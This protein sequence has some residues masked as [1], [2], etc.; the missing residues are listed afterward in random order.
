MVLGR[1]DPLPLFPFPFL[2]MISPLRTSTVGGIFPRDCCSVAVTH[3][4][5]RSAPGST[6]PSPCCRRVSQPGWLAKVVVVLANHPGRTESEASFA[7]EPLALYPSPDRCSTT[8][9]C[10]PVRGLEGP[11]AGTTIYGFSR[12]FTVQLTS[13]IH[14]HARPQAR[15]SKGAPFYLVY[16]GLL[17]YH[18]ASARSLRSRPTDSPSPPRRTL[19]P[20]AARRPNPPARSP[21]A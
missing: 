21:S 16:S 4:T 18:M 15:T 20:F 1:G 9:L 17:Q 2:K 10:R 3:G 13:Q 11:R 19:A 8:C 7:R 6:D 14:D 5:Q 12:N